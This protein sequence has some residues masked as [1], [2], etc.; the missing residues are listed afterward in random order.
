MMVEGETLEIG[1]D[2]DGE[3]VPPQFAI[4]GGAYLLLFGRG[5]FFA[6]GGVIEEG[7][8]G[9]WEGVAVLEHAFW[10]GDFAIEEVL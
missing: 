9:L 4:G 6:C 1:A 8:G 3:M 2:G 5:V 10:D 7:S